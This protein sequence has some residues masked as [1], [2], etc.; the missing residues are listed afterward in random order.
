MPVCEPGPR[1]L[2]TPASSEELISPIDA[3]PCS[4]N[5]WNVGQKWEPIA[6]GV[7]ADVRTGVSQLPT[8]SSS[9]EA[10]EAKAFFSLLP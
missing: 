3:T 10:H 5:F 1:G 8:L 6:N 2:R 7:K 4:G 9:P